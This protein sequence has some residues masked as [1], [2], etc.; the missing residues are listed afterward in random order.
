MKTVASI[1]DLNR[2]AVETG[3]VVSIGGK[4]LNSQGERMAG[5]RKPK[6]PEAP[7]P[8]PAPPPP[9]AGV[10]LEEV[11][12]LLAERDAV[13]EQ[14]MTGLSNALLMLSRA[15]APGGVRAWDFSVEYGDKHQITSI[16]AIALDP[17][18]PTQ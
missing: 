15:P 13:W 17:Q 9:P 4:V 12:R 1:S 2:L 16:R 14:R 6:P 18:G 8:E 10:S 5:L 3:A 7:K 11:Q